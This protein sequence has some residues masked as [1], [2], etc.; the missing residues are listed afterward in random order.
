MTR[1]AGLDTDAPNGAGVRPLEQIRVGW[2]R[3]GEPSDPV[4]LL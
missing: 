3:P 2:N 4:N 1:P